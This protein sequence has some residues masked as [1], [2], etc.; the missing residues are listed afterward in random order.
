MDKYSPT[1]SEVYH[2][3]LP[4][5]NE[6]GSI[7]S[8]GYGLQGEGI[9]SCQEEMKGEG[10]ENGG[11]VIS[12]TYRSGANQYLSIAYVAYVEKS[13]TLLRQVHLGGRR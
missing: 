1:G 7:N 5:Q 8:C 2:Q 11:D 9:N 10:V 12:T 4:I 13:T 3:L 6:G